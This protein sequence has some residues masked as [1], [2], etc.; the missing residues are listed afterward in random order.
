M[1]THW[2]DKEAAPV[3]G[4]RNPA[5][6]SQAMRPA[7][8]K[9]ARLWAADAT[10]TMSAILEEVSRLERQRLSGTSPDP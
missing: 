1:R 2:T 8:E 4:L 10:R 9:I 5:K 3:L 6:V 7:L